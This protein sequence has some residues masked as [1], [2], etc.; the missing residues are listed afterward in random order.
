MRRSTWLR[1]KDDYQH[2]FVY[3]AA[4]SIC[5][6]LRSREIGYFSN[7]AKQCIVIEHVYYS[8]FSTTTPRYMVIDK[9]KGK[10]TSIEFKFHSGCLNGC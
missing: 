2:E 4:K 10:S 6:T 7:R 8:W 5:M 3:K 1:S 9:F